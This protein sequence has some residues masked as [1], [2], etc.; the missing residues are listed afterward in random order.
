MRE[1][2]TSAA[3]VGGVVLFAVAGGSVAA[4]KISRAL[5]T[6]PLAATAVLD[7]TAAFNAGDRRRLSRLVA[8][9][10]RFKWYS[11]TRSS[12][13]HF[14]AYK[15]GAFL[16]YGAERHAL[17][18][19]LA[20]TNFRYQGRSRAQVGNRAELVGGF[21]YTLLRR[22]DDLAEGRPERYRGKGVVSCTSWGGRL[23]VWS[24]GSG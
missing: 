20:I 22:A 11:V 12:T 8:D 1:S 3:A 14:V 7:F 13:E 9:A 23:M 10:P 19:S 4:P 15:K 24:M 16:R 18:E 6:R 2:R 17:H 5:C 21:S